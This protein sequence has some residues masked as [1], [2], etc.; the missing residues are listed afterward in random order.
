MIQ[1]QGRKIAGITLAASLLSTL[2][3][4]LVTRAQTPE[5]PE[6]AE[7]VGTTVAVRNRVWTG[8]PAGPGL[9]LRSFDPLYLDMQIHTG[10][11]SA[12][13]LLLAQIRGTNAR[14]RANA[15][16][17][18]LAAEGHVTLRESEVFPDGRRRSVI[19]VAA[20]WLQVAVS[21]GKRIEA[22]VR[23]LDAVIGIQGTLLWVHVGNAATVVVVVE[24]AVTVTGA[25]G[26]T[27]LRVGAGQVTTIARG[28]APSLPRPR[29]PSDQALAPSAPGNVFD[30]PGDE[31]DPD[32]EV[33]GPDELPIIRDERQRP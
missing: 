2:A 26:G 28:R 15:M 6:G 16:T 22:I 5:A 18:R 11:R 9:D 17:L 20:G 4:A 30:P 25:A 23:T 13:E 32:F 10:K 33:I 1:V 19:D 8:P 7:R 21:P 3:L 14:E 29:D 31:I 27:P 24:G 12:A